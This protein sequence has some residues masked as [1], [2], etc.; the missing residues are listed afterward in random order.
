M[1]SP[2][3][4]ILRYTKNNIVRNRWLSLATI[5]VST[6]IFTTA[7]LFIA[8]SLLAQKAVQVAETKAQLRVYFQ[9]EAP[10]DE[11]DKVQALLEVQDGLEKITFISQEEALEIYLGY[12]T[13]NKDL[14]E[15]VSADWLPASLEVQ[16]ESL[17][18]LE[19]ITDVVK[20]EEKA[21]P[22]IDE[23]EY[24]EDVVDQLKSISKG[25]NIGGIV[26]I[27]IFTIITFS[28]IIITI[29]FNI[30]AHKSEIEIMHLVGS[31][32]RDISLPFILEGIFYTTLGSF[33]SGL[34]IIIPWYLIMH[35][36]EGTNAQFILQDII[37][38]LG[39]EYLLSFNIGFTSIYLGAHVVV[40]IL[41]GLIGSTIAV[42]KYL[43]LKEN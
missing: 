42:R 27:T 11:I 13:D 14:A 32:D 29:S 10:Q 37:R 36:G 12:S 22:Y 43:N 15:T 30:M 4:K 19:A 39:V 33:I 7:S 34:M 1:E 25:I 26:I 41:I 38:E 35:Y 3:I 16:A 17:E 20:E 24:R 21:N 5:L 40:A 31:K 6:I 18:D 9:V 23:V 2:F 28:L 8:S